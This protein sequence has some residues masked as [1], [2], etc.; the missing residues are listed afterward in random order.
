MKQFE[1]N[2]DDFLKVIE[3]YFGVRGFIGGMGNYS[4]YVLVFGYIVNQ[5]KVRVK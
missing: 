1:Y 2:E 4:G 5:E 3:E